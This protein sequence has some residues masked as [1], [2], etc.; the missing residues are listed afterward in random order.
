MERNFLQRIGIIILALLMAVFSANAY[1]YATREIKTSQ[2]RL[3][4]PHTADKD[5]KLKKTLPNGAKV[6][7]SQNEK[8]IISSR[9]E[10]LVQLTI[11]Y[12]FDSEYLFHWGTLI[13]NDFIC[14]ED[15]D[16]EYD[17]DNN[18]LTAY[19]APG[20]Y[21]IVSH[22]GY[23]Y[24]GDLSEA[25]MPTGHRLAVK[26][27][28]DVNEDMTI[29]M[30]ASEC[31]NRIH[32]D[33]YMP[34][35]E[36]PILPTMK[37]LDHEPWVEWDLEN[38]N[39]ADVLVTYF[40]MIN[41]MLLIRGTGNSG[42]QNNLPMDMND[43]Y[44]ND[45]SDR[46]YIR[47]TRTIEG[48]EPEYYISSFSVNGSKPAMIETL[49]SDYKCMSESFET[50]KN[51][52]SSP[53]GHFLGF[54]SIEMLDRVQFGGWSGNN[55]EDVGDLR[56]VTIYN[57]IDKEYMEK[58][59]RHFGIMVMPTFTDYSYIQTTIYD[60]GDGEIYEDKFQVFYD[61]MGLPMLI[62]GDKIEYVN[63]G[64]DAYGNYS[65]QSPEYPETTIYEYPGH[66]VFT[67]MGDQKKMEYGNSAPV[68]AFMAQNSYQEWYESNMSYFDICYIGQA[69]DIR[70]SDYVNLD[71]DFKFDGKQRATKYAEAD[72]VLNVMAENKECAGIYDITFDNKNVLVDGVPGYNRTHVVYDG[73][74]EDWTA[75]TLQMLQ[76]RNND[77]DITNKFENSEDGVLEFAGGDF[78]FVYNSDP[79]YAYF[80]CEE[81]IVNV[82]YSPYGEDAWT[83]L[84]VEELE[85]Y[86]VR[87]AF[88]YF[89]RG[90]LDVVKEMSENG[91]FDLRIK[92]TDLS[93]NYQEQ[94]ISPAFKINSKSGVKSVETSNGEIVSSKY[95]TIDGRVAPKDT[96]GLIIRSDQYSDGTWQHKIVKQ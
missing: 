74:K 83:P 36:L 9:S 53:M 46:L 71:M 55:G 54:N 78:N 16:F 7:G 91:W 56:T 85:E 29:R 2:G 84:P 52:E 45:C 76:L 34:N 86:Y 42:S 32:C 87:P 48:Y 13:S 95:F 18:I 15:W 38:S 25:K 68:A 37:M 47:L 30:S 21:D 75:P 59:P 94:V 80:D 64:H 1:V 26:E 20:T 17:Y 65:F 51:G 31:T 12:D 44:V 27:N 43:F 73:R 67:Y 72:S 57:T 70:T 11:E 39:A 33:T 5:L 77:G 23:G 35:G 82:E 14:Y 41:N 60:W 24:N 3:T 4:P 22:F 66:P 6:Y 93:D 92:L 62:D 40:V 50:T 63:K 88:G 96:K 58:D 90:K 49:P 81:Q 19:V 79:Y 61:T 10:E 89:Y 8:Q 28:I 69:G